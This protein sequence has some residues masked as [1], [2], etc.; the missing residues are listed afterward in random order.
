MP[1]LGKRLAESRGDA[2]VS[3]KPEDFASQEADAQQAYMGAPLDYV[4]VANAAPHPPLDQKLLALI[5][6]SWK[7]AS[8]KEGAGRSRMAIGRRDL[9]GSR[10]AV[11]IGRQREGIVT[12][13]FRAAAP[14]GYRKEAEKL[15][16]HLKTVVP[17]DWKLMQQIPRVSAYGFRGDRRGPA[18]IAKAGGFQP[19]V[20]RTDDYYVKTCI[21]P[22]FSAYLKTKLDIDI[23]L[24]EF[25][26]II[27][28]T[29]LDARERHVLA[30]YSMWR[31]QVAN[32]AMHI[33]RMLAQ[34]DLKGY[35]STTKATSVAKGFARANGHVYLLRVDGG[36]HI[37][38]KGRHEWT[39]I[40]GEEE[41]ASPFPIGWNDVVGYRKVNDDRKFTG[42]IFF[43]PDFVTNDN[44]AFETCYKLLSGMVQAPARP[45]ARAPVR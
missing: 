39:A 24:P 42:P 27:R 35:V 43:R 23:A 30:Y 44:A 2:F 31:S 40:F 3:Y 6:S 22:T 28:T 7:R 26:R 34:E 8:P 33:G 14:V 38:S 29:L 37:P 13:T 1:F 21:Y 36:F 19:P 16:A 5:E 41:I 17:F 15:A 32:E 18:E 45:Q 10:G 12:P 20:S 11:Q 4:P 25:E 9:M